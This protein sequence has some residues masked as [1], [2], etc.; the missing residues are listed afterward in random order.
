MSNLH[1]D[2][3]NKVHVDIVTALNWATFDIIGDLS[4]AESFHNLELRHPHIWL[5][6]IL[7]SIRIGVA[8]RQLNTLPGF[9][10]FLNL[11][12]NTLRNRIGFDFLPYTKTLIDKRIKQGTARPDFMSRVL[13][14]NR[15]DGTGITRDEIDATMAM[16]VIGGS[17][18]TS[19][20]LA[21][22]V[23]LLLRNP[24]K[25]S[26]LREEI[27]SEFN[28]ADDITIASTSRLP[29]LFAVLEESLR[30][31]PPV[32]VA[33][34]RIVPPEGASIC[35]YW[36]HGGVSSLEK[37]LN[38]RRR[39]LT[40]HRRLLEFHNMQPTIPSQT[41]LNQT[42]SYLNDGFRIKMKYTTMIAQP[43]FNHSQQDLETVWVKSKLI[44]IYQIKL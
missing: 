22:C 26:K 15:E 36:V 37:D 11:L 19:T 27:L 34:S 29:Y 39:I 35:G 38:L 40:F 28:R 20:L 16:V 9:S 43:F 2:A 12:Q 33:L 14:N 8:F 7:R 25:M 18:T 5:S 24:E 4:F 13:E 41:L 30:I 32:P 31:Y 23:Y 21:G 42:I 17:E 10:F 1:E 3:K 44:C 6:T